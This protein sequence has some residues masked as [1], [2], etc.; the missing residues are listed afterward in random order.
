MLIEAVL[1][2]NKVSQNLPSFSFWICTPFNFG[3][4][5]LSQWLVRIKLSVRLKGVT[6]SRSLSDELDW[7]WSVKQWRTIIR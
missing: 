6:S 4:L 7:D 1:K 5:F 3:L 2:S